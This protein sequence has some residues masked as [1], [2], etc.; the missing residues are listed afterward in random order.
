LVSQDYSNFSSVLSGPQ[1]AASYFR[2]YDCLG[3]RV[4]ANEPL[5][6]GDQRLTIN[7]GAGVVAARMTLHNANHPPG[8]NCS[9]P[10]VGQDPCCC[11]NELEF[12]E[13]NCQPKNSPASA[14]GISI[15]DNTYRFINQ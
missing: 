6:Q 13:G 10:P 1:E 5:C 7:I 11:A 4:S 14:V 8:V 3:R 12:L 9:P 2:L 15:I